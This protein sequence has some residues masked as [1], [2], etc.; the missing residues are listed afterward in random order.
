MADRALRVSLATLPEMASSPVNL[1]STGV[2]MS[3]LL[4]SFIRQDINAILDDWHKFC[5]E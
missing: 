2:A 3:S 5:A 4:A 1:C